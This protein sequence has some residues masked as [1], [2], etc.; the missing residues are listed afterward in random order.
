MH[1]ISLLEPPFGNYATLSSPF[2]NYKHD[3]FLS[4]DSLLV[5][6]S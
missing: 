4:D 3:T 5:S 6:A 2:A 1:P